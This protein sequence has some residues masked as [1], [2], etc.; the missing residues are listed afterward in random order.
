MIKIPKNIDLDVTSRYAREVC[1]NSGL[2]IMN[3]PFE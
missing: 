3:K 2:V 1:Q